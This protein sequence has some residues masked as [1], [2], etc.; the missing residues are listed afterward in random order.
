MDC[1]KKC[2]GPSTFTGTFA[3]QGEVK[4]TNV[5]FKRSLRA[6]RAARRVG[7]EGGALCD[8]RVQVV[9]THPSRTFV[10]LGAPSGPGDASKTR[11]AIGNPIWAVGGKEEPFYI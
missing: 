1:G 5:I 8:L 6:L 7:T 3:A 10:G 11:I 4:Q 2:R 9:R